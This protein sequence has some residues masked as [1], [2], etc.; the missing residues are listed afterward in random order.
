MLAGHA[1]IESPPGGIRDSDDST[2][3]ESSLGSDQIG[4]FLSNKCTFLGAYEIRPEESAKA[5]MTGLVAISFLTNPDYIESDIPNR[6]RWVTKFFKTTSFPHIFRFYA[7][8]FDLVRRS[9]QFLVHLLCLPFGG[10]GYYSMLRSA[11]RWCGWRAYS[12]ANM[13]CTFRV[14]SP[15]MVT[16]TIGGLR[17][18]WLST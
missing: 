7:L 4:S 5:S 10:E 6:F 2:A 17:N 18:H 3:T 8:Y 16:R 1:T 9:Y 14:P 15:P 12:L 11:T 13:P